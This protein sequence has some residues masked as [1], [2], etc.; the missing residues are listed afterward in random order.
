MNISLQCKGCKRIFGFDAN[1]PEGSTIT[2][3][4]LLTRSLDTGGSCP[5]KCG[6]CGGEL[7][8]QQSEAA[9]NG[10]DSAGGSQSC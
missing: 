9:V 1:I 7:K 5:A 8:M 3:A 10:G 2:S 4:E 6:W